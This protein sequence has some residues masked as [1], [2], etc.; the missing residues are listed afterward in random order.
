MDFSGPAEG[1][2]QS[3]SLN[4]NLAQNSKKA[5]TD[6]SPMV[7]RNGS[8]SLLRTAPKLLAA[9]NLWVKAGLKFSF[10]DNLPLLPHIH[11]QLIDAKQGAAP[12]K[13]FVLRFR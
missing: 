4:S 6:P 13:F 8:T 5:A 12:K 7:R 3:Q 1:G 9:G 11:S 10:V 2:L